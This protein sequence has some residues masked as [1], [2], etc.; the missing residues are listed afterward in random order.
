MADGRWV[1]GRGI[2]CDGMRS[3]CWRVLGDKYSALGR[4]REEKAMYRWQKGAL[5]DYPLG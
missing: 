4:L 5:P 1:D 2:L 3:S